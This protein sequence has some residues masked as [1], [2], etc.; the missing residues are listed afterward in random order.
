MVKQGTIKFFS[1]GAKGV[2]SFPSRRGTAIL[3][4]FPEREKVQVKQ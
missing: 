4:D 1:W 3:G 2:N